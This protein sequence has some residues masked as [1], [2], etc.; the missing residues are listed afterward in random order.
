VPVV[1]E[2]CHDFIKVLKIGNTIFGK[3]QGSFLLGGYIG[4]ARVGA[5]DI[6]D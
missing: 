6:T 2:A 1:D 5:A 3:R 4:K